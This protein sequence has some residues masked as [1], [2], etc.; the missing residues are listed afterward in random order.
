VKDNEGNTVS[1]AAVQRD[2]TVRHQNE[3]RLFKQLEES[4]ALLNISQMLAGTLDLDP[5]LQQIARA[6]STLIKASDR[7]I[8]HLLDDT[9]N[10]LQA[11]AVSGEVSDHT[12][13]RMNFRLGEGVAGIALASG[14][15]INIADVFADE[16]YILPSYETGRPRS[17]MVAPVMTGKRKLG[18]L[19]VQ[20]FKPG[21]FTVDDEGLLTILGTQAALAIEKIGSPGTNCCF[22]N[23]RI[24]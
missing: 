18:T 6:A 1:Y 20:S 24:E 15:T 13:G 17:L 4:Q 7:T 10:Y 23:T 12:G 14:K 3:E 5:T 9:G 22:G 16:R 2:A 11:V 8:L 21:A 19:S